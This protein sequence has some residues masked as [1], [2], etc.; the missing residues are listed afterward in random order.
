MA[1]TFTP[2]A[3]KTIR[4]DDAAF[5]VAT[6]EIYVLGALADETAPDSVDEGDR[7]ALRMTLDR[8]L[9]VQLRGNDGN[10]GAGTNRR[11][12]TDAAGRLAIQDDGL[13]I[14]VDGS[15]D[16]EL[17]AAAAL[18]DNAANPT[19]PSVGAF[20][21]V[22]D[23]TTWDRLRGN[24]EGGV[25]VQGPGAVGAAPVG[26]PVYIAGTDGANLRAVKVDANGELQVDVLSGGGEPTPTSPQI[27]V[28]NSTNTA[29]GASATL[30]AGDLASGPWRLWAVDIWAAVPYKAQIFKVENGT[31]TEVGRGGGK[32]GE[33][34]R[35]APPHRNFVQV[36]GG[37]AGLDT[38]RAVVT[39]QDNAQAA[40][41]HAVFYYSQ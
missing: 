41:L 27:A 34:W 23:G 11:I 10:D 17:P 38:F 13:S 32:A 30:E 3:V 9:L 15:V 16:T 33:P 18:T 26:N 36:A 28:Q 20:G 4:L 21:H 19:V 39:N 40:D 29:A 12:K 7:G 1:D 2:V 24:A 14:T 22:Y 35:F 5:G 6:E 37:T 31:P 25:F 8:V